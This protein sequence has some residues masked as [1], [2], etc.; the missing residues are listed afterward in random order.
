MRRAN[1]DTDS[2]TLLSACHAITWKDPV[3][4]LL[5]E[6]VEKP[7]VTVTEGSQSM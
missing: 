1:F 3:T 7:W 6:V 5:F 2:G 4:F